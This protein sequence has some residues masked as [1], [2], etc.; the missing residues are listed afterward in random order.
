MKTSEI[1][2]E[3]GRQARRLAARVIAGEITMEKAI[4]GLVSPQIPRT[5]AAEIINGHIEALRGQR[6]LR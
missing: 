6:F 2:S 5:L 4:G 1:V 3:A